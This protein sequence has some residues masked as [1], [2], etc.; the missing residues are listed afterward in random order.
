[1]NTIEEIL[2]NKNTYKRYK[3]EICPRCINKNNKID[4]CKV[5]R[6][7]DNTVKCINFSKCMKNKCNTCED[8]KECFK[9]E[10]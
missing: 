2:E 4:L 10:E 3:E 1:M 6:R 9:E 7:I 8:E 5:T